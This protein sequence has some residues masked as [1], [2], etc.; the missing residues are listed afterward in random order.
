MA[1]TLLIGISTRLMHMTPFDLGVGGKKLQYLEDSFAHFVSGPGM[2]AVMVPDPGMELPLW[3]DLVRSYARRLDGLVLQ[4]GA[5]IAPGAY[6]QEPLRPEWSGDILRDRYE[7]A[8]TEAFL[9]AGKPILGICRGAQ[10]L[11]VVLGGTLLQDISTQWPGAAQ[12]RDGQRYDALRHRVAL[13]PD[14]RLASLYAP[15]SEGWVTSI[16]HQAVDRLGRGL[17][18]E[19]RSAD[20]GVVEAFRSRELPYVVGIQWHPEFHTDESLLSAHPILE[21]FLEACRLYQGYPRTT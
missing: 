13:E 21:D 16:H 20:D 17:V 12:H 4:G 10:L 19:A 7:F 1:E 6:G 8:L 18:V 2:L 15:A 5:D 9:E 11:N 14:S 3:Q